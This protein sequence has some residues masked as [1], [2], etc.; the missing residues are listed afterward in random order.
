MGLNT[1]SVGEPSLPSYKLLKYIVSLHPSPPPLPH[2][3][4]YLQEFTNV[5]G[6]GDKKNLVLSFSWNVLLRKPT[7]AVITVG[8]KNVTSSM[9][10]NEASL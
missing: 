6:S 7:F 2:P 3:T 1:N 8:D 10:C 4:L 5:L 9:Q